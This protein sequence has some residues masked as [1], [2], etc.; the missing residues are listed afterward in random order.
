MIRRPPRS[1]LFPYTTLFRSH[2]RTAGDSSHVEVCAAAPA[3]A[4][5][6]A[7]DSQGGV[8]E[9]QRRLFHGDQ[10]RQPDGRLCDP[11]PAPGAGDAS[12]IEAAD[13]HEEFAGYGAHA[14]L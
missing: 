13:W 3:H 11:Q 1:T 10:N 12:T 14:R 7:E 8:H 9:P 2:A 6:A 5:A 4:R